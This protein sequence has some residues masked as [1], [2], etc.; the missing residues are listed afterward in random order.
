ME[1]TK[2]NRNQPNKKKEITNKIAQANNGITT[3]RDVILASSPHLSELNDLHTER[4]MSKASLLTQHKIK[5]IYH[6]LGSFELLTIAHN[7]IYKNKGAATK[8]TSE[9]TVD[10]I[11]DSHLL[12]IKL[13]IDTK[14]FEWSSIRRIEIEKPG[15]KPRP[16][17]ISNYTDKLVQF[18]IALILNAI[19]DP[20][21]SDKN[22]NFG[23]R[24]NYSSH[25]NLLNILNYKNQGLN[26]AI[27]GDISG[28]FDQ[29]NHKKLIGILK[30]TIDDPDF[31]D[32]IERA[33]KAK[34]FTFDGLGALKT[35]T[36]PE[37]GTTQGYICSPILFN[38]YAFDLDTFITKHLDDKLEKLNQKRI[39]PLRLNP[40]YKDLDN[41]I[42]RITYKIGII[43]KISLIR[44]LTQ[45]EEKTIETSKKQIN[46]YKEKRSHLPSRDP[47]GIT[48]RYYYTRYADDFLILTNA[49]LEIC[50]EIKNIL[51]EYL[52]TRLALELN[53][54]KT[55]I[56]NLKKNCAKFLGFVLYM[57]NLSPKRTQTNN[58]KMGTTTRRGGSIIIKAGI[59]F[60]R[61]NKQLIEKGYIRIKNN[62]MFPS[63]VPYLTPFSEYEIV[64]HFNQVMDG[65]A[66]YYFRIIHN[67]SQLNSILYYLYY[68][69]LFTISSKRKSSVPTIFKENS[70]NELDLKGR[71]TNKIK[72]VLSQPNPITNRQGETNEF[73]TLL[74][75]ADVMNR[76][77]RI[78]YNM[79]YKY[80]NP[81]NIVNENYWKLMKTNWRSSTQ[82]PK[83]C[84]I[85]GTLIDVEIHHTN[86]LRKTSPKKSKTKIP[87]YKFL[88]SINRK[89]IP[90]CNKHHHEIHK[91][92]YDECLP[93]ISNY[94]KTVQSERYI[95]QAGIDSK[96]K[97][98]PNRFRYHAPT[99]TVTN[100]FSNIDFRH[101]PKYVPN[102]NLTL[103]MNSPTTMQLF[104]KKYFNPPTEEQSKPLDPQNQD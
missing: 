62:K 35:S 102:L 65:I 99:K 21:F 15:K 64:E 16:I 63:R 84:L 32:I 19:Y 29:V 9:Q 66:N 61:R 77:L 3:P 78:A 95:L 71:P 36:T 34:I 55:I 5:N 97:I 17:G 53:E 98:F 14:Q 33:C 28:A 27:E 52:K 70:W 45:E 76:A 100:P 51:K 31:L 67:K 57:S 75:Y 85:C 91:G 7:T 80:T 10:G 59:D 22:Y 87:L 8:G 86:A 41:T 2:R 83:I 1:T 93:N 26:M 20:I 18:V 46:F 44:H 47:D 6:Y 42:R 49:S 89:K 39:N 72:I 92:L 68:S 96:Y 30:R 40:Q 13:L 82:I 43:K 24:P 48:L 37:M 104:I 25:D 60:E 38:I 79:D 4:L 101:R 23:F 81:H 73:I 12:N 58:K 56:T 103:S 90:L 88:S 50:T 54:K 94:L 74:N 11:P 69:C